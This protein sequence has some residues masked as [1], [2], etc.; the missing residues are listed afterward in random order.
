MAK[1]INELF[2]HIM[3]VM[4]SN[5]FFY[6]ENFCIKAILNEEESGYTEVMITYGTR[7]VAM[8]LRLNHSHTDIQYN[9]NK[10]L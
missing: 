5:G 7:S 3:S 8:C 2:G 10:L 9:I 4:K 1:L 6:L